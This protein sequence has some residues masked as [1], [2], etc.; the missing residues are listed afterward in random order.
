MLPKVGRYRLT[1]LESDAYTLTR[2]PYL[3]VSAIDVMDGRLLEF[4][5]QGLP[6]VFILGRLYRAVT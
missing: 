3:Q 6:M 4:G 1:E 2:L 5:L